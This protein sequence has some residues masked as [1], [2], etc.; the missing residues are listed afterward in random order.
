KHSSNPIYIIAGILA[1][2]L[3][4][5]TA[6]MGELSDLNQH[7]LLSVEK[8]CIRMETINDALQHIYH[9]VSSWPLFKAWNINTIAHGSLDGLKLS[10][11]HTHYKAR[12][13]QKYFGT[14]AGLSSYNLILNHF[15]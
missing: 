10:T 3:G 13:S 12:F 1:N 5:S 4:I 14:D 9:S 2:A 11:Q 6:E 8:A 7:S 15:P